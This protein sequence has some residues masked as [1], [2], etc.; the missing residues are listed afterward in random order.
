M[1]GSRRR[2]PASRPTGAAG[3]TSAARRSAGSKG[4][5][6]RIDRG[7]QPRPWRRVA[8]SLAVSIVVVGF[9]LV[10]VFPTQDWLTQRDEAEARQEELGAIRAE[11]RRLE[12][13]IAELETPGEVE[14][15]A[16]EEFGMTR[17]GET[18]YRVLPPAVDAVD[19]PDS[20]PF[21]GAD[22]YLNR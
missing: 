12:Q 15:I 4:S 20:W 6:R 10:A 19:L 18:S 1:S 7:R 9:L 17:P 3:A 22:D 13:R 2:P 21:T 11:E 14:R 16:R 8:A 5:P